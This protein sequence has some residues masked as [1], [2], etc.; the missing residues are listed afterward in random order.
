VV[1]ALAVALV[2]GAAGTWLALAGDR[3]SSDVATNR[4]RVASTFTATTL[5]PTTTTTLPPGPPFGV[6]VL[7]V[8]VEDT[9][10]GTI[11][12]GP[13]AASPTRRLPLTVHYPAALAFESPVTENAPSAP[14]TFPL[15]IFA[16]GYAINA[17]A[18]DVVTADLAAGGF[19]VIAPDFPIS[20]TAFPGP[21]S[22]ADIANQARDM[23]FLITVFETAASTPPLLQGHVAPGK[24]GVTGHSDG[25]ASAAEA[26]GNSC[27]FDERIGA[28]APLAGDQAFAPGAWG[29][30]NAS[31][32][33]FIHG[34]NDR[35]VPYAFSEKLYTDTRST[36]YL[37]SVTGAPHFEP[38]VT[39]PQRSAIIPL[40]L[41]FFRAYLIS[42]AAALAR[43]PADANV[44]GVLKLEASA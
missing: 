10:R 36:K 8:T 29:L 9:T 2:A 3:S 44:P 17:A 38:F 40:M 30:P 34:T 13:T 35:D 31:P 24:V 7:K 39:A 5:P 16:H 37:V 22:Q 25:G 41:D 21:P 4:G 6:G 32:Q 23:G 20:S 43:V 26:S 28:S 11:A 15:L 1:G 18:Y 12:R 27:C 33:L 14:G 19:I 42:D